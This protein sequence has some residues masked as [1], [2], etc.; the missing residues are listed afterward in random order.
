MPYNNTHNILFIHIPKSAGTSVLKMFNMSEKE[1]HISWEK[2]KNLDENI[3]QNAY[4]FAI[5]RNPWDKFVSC[6]E[7][8]KMD[9]SYWHSI[10]GE[11]IYGKHPDYDLTNKYDNFNDFVKFL[12]EIKEPHLPLKSVNWSYQYQWVCDNGIGV[13]IDTLYRFEHMD[14]MINDLNEKFNFQFELPHINKSNNKDY[15]KYYNDNSIEFV[16]KIYKRD[17]ELFNYKFD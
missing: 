5:V 2:Y 9:K 1:G 4:K 17:I 16:N 3:Y 15:R 12:S 14:Y 11:S 7:Y 13:K 10:D 6:Y 8:V